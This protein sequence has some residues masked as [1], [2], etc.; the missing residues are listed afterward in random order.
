MLKAG[1][2]F[3]Q[4]NRLGLPD[5]KYLGTAY[6]ANT[7]SGGPPVFQCYLLGILDLLFTPALKAIGFHILTPPSKFGYLMR[8]L[9]E[10]FYLGPIK[11]TY[12]PV[13]SI[14]P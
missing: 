2:L 14:E 1:S 13:D 9:F 12:T 6:R 11:I 7:L 8:Y 5:S 3:R 4:P 10:R